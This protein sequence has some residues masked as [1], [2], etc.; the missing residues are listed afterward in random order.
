MYIQFICNKINGLL[1][2]LEVFDTFKKF[3]FIIS[4]CE[5]IICKIVGGKDLVEEMEDGLIS[6]QN[7]KQITYTLVSH[8]FEKFG[9]Q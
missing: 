8:L 6:Y 1:L 5:Q 7:R 3:F 9:K 4:E 2:Y